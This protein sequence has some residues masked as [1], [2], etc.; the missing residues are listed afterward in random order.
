MVEIEI[1]GIPVDCTKHKSKVISRNSVNPIWNEMY[2]FH[3][4]RLNHG[5][6]LAQ[7]NSLSYVIKHIAQHA[8]IIITITR[9][10]YLLI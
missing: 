1:I 6:L 10:L 8:G 3:V 2:T 7:H 9:L 4:S 5:A